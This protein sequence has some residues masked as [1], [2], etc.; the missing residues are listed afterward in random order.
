MA[1]KH[2]FSLTQ[3]AHSTWRIGQIPHKRTRIESKI[4]VLQLP[5]FHTTFRCLI[6]RFYS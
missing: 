1:F 3:N 4:K 5:T 2:M 6:V